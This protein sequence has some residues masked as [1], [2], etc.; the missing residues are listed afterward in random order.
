MLTFWGS[1]LSLGWLN[2][3]CS[4]DVSHGLCQSSLPFHLHLCKD[5]SAAVFQW[6]FHSIFQSNLPFLWQM[7]IWWDQSWIYSWFLF[8]TSWKN[9]K[10]MDQ[11]LKL[12]GALMSSQ[13]NLKL[14]GVH[15]YLHSFEQ[16]NM[17][18]SNNSLTPCEVTPTPHN[19]LSDTEKSLSTRCTKKILLIL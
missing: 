1:E 8:Q 3:S 10:L 19:I 6:A 11:T 7:T 2:S 5:G 13:T 9:F 15:L 4:G 12:R 18:I 14:V 16:H 17:Q